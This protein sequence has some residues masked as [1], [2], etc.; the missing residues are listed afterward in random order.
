[1]TQTTQS[2]PSSP[3]VPR[4]DADS[5]GFWESTR[6]GQLSIDRCSEC[7]RWQHPPL[8]ACRYCGSPNEFEPVSGRGSVFTFIIVRQ[9]TVPGHAAP[10]V[11]AVVE[12]EEQSDIR[13]TGVVQGPIEAVHIGMPVEARLVQVGDSTFFAPEFV[14]VTA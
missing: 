6:S 10:Y 7:R 12:L 11:V 1:M 5:A 2:P 4:P 9:Q 3:P 13:V 14:P 8:E